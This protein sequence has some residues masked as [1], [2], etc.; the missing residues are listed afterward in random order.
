MVKKRE[1]PTATVMVPR[2]A[3]ETGSQMKI[4]TAIR[5]VP[6]SEIQTAFRTEIQVPS[7]PS[8]VK[9]WVRH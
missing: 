8:S 5:T 1:I 6:M 9:S 7:L 4:L 2:K 3:P